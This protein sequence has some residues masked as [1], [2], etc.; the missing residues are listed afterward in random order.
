MVPTT[1]A[2]WTIETIDRLVAVGIFESRTFDFK[3]WMPRGADEPG[4]ARLKKTVAA[5]A[6]ETGGFLVFGVKDDRTLPVKDRIVGVPPD[7]DVPALFGAQAARCTPAVQWDQ[8][9]PPHKLASGN[10][11]HVIEIHEGSSKPHGIYDGERWIFPKRTEGGNE[12]LS[13]ERNS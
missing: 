1:L 10:Y 6:N 7:C 5:F 13:Y 9:N 11:V 8:L 2:A 12:L 4:K 3:E